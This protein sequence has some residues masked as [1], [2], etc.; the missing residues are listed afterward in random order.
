MGFDAVHRNHVLSVSQVDGE[1]FG[2]A[3]QNEK[4]AAVCGCQRPGGAALL[5]VDVAGLG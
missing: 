4:G 1:E 5:D 2:R 3:L